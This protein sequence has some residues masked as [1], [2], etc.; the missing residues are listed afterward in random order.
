MHHLSKDDLL[1]KETLLPI[2]AIASL[3]ALGAIVGTA[4]HRRSHGRPMIGQHAEHLMERG[5][6]RVEDWV[7]WAKLPDVLEKMMKLWAK[8]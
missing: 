5:K 1:N 8:Q 3:A 7:D 6:E 4:M 2:V